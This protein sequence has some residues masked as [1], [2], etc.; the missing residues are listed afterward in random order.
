MRTDKALERQAE[1]I[2]AKHRDTNPGGRPGESIAKTTFRTG[3]TVAERREEAQ[4]RR[5]S[6]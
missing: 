6:R 1:Q 5:G 3:R 2:A 4:S